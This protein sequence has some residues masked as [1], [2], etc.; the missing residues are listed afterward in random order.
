METTSLAGSNYNKYENLTPKDFINLI[1]NDKNLENEFCFLNK[2]YHPY[3]W[4]IVDF[5]ERNPKLYLSISSRGITQFND[6]DIR[7]LSM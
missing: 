5:K 4:V 2:R 6:G 7:F 1:K 3:D